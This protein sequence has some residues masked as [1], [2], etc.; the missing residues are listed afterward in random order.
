MYEIH[1]KNDL[2]LFDLCAARHRG[3]T[4]SVAAYQRIALTVDHQRMRVLEEVMASGDSGITCR[5]LADKWN[6]GM[7]QIS[8]RFSEL[9]AA[10][11]ISK[12]GARGGCAVLVANHQGGK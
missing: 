10:G 7:N 4:E 11:L 1:R 9:K 12:T 8:G 6:V 5:E 2:P 3:A